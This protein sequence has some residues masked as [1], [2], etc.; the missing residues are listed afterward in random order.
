MESL[1]PTT[2]HF[3]TSLLTWDHLVSTITWLIVASCLLGI[4]TQLTTRR[5]K[6]PIPLAEEMSDPIARRRAYAPLSKQLLDKFYERFKNKPYGLETMDGTKI[7]LPLQYLDELKSHPALSFKASID[8]DA[9]LP[10]T[11]VGGVEAWG[12][13]QILAKMNPTLGAYVPVFHGLIQ[14]H[15]PKLVGLHAEWTPVNLSEALLEMVAIMSARIMHS[16]EAARNPTWLKLS[17]SFVHTAI[18]YGSALKSWPPILRPIIA[19]FLPQRLEKEKQLAGG[20]EII[21]KSLARKK[22][23]GGAPLENPPT[24]LDHLTSGAHASKADDLEL[25]LILQMTLA[26]ASI[27][28]TSSTITQVL[29]DLA[30]QPDRAEELRMEVVEVLEKSGGVFTKQSLAEMKKL[31]SWM[32]E[33]LRMS[34]PDMTTFQR[35]ATKP[36][37]LKDGTYIPAGTKMELPTSAINYDPA[38]Y[39]NP[40][41]FDGMRSYRERQEEGSEHKHFFVSVTRTELGWGFGRHACPGRFLSDVEIKLMFAEFLLNYEIKNPEGEPRFKNIEFAT[42]VLPDPTKEVLI[43]VRRC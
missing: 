24:M 8:N 35:M 20:R 17:T 26:V 15:L 14:E 39:P 6:V 41:K 33:S 19:Y 9:L 23:L 43:R 28:T 42:N 34:A 3:D 12:A 21:A 7:V 31:D 27:H 13:H 32:K 25:Q 18:E 38:I 22:A 2:I 1:L 10:Y 29:Y 16:E 36:L 40:E 11:S 5:L 30:V 37:T 4:L